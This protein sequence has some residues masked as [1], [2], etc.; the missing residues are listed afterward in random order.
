MKT[1]GK[2]LSLLLVAALVLALLAGCSAQNS[3]YSDQ[4]S[5]NA[6]DS[7]DTG[8]EAGSGKDFDTSKEIGVISREDAPGLPPPW[9]RRHSMRRRKKTA[10]DRASY[11]PAR[12]LKVQRARQAQGLK[13]Y[14]PALRTAA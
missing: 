11:L 3:D 8:S 4:S 13:S 10:R 2:I 14:P 1:S 7:A 6:G 12:T 5:S 9:L